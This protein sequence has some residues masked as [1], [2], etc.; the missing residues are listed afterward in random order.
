MSFTPKEG[1]ITKITIDGQNITNDI[2][3]EYKKFDFKDKVTNPESE[4]FF[5]IGDRVAE[6]H[7]LGSLSLQVGVR[8]KLK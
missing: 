6:K 5:P 3:S 2:P 7:P 1:E 4:D 8:F